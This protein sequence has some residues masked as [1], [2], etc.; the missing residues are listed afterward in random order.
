M[1]SN[2]DWFFSFEKLDSYSIVMGD[3]C[4]CNMKEIDAVLVK[5]FDEMVRKLKEVRYVPQ[6]RK[7]LSQ[8]VS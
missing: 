3:D 1:C 2:R 6:L 8:L 5:M 4:T 7:I